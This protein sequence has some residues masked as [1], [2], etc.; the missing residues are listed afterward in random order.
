MARKPKSKPT[1]AEETIFWANEQAGCLYRLRGRRTPKTLQV[2]D[3][4]LLVGSAVS[5][6]WVPFEN[7]RCFQ[8]ARDAKFWLMSKL[9]A[10]QQATADQHTQL[11]VAQATLTDLFSRLPTPDPTLCPECGGKLFVDLGYVRFAD[12]QFVLLNETRTCRACWQPPHDRPSYAVIRTLGHLPYVLQV[13]RISS[14]RDVCSIRVEA[15]LMQGAGTR[16]TYT[17]SDNLPSVSVGDKLEC[18]RTD[19]FVSL[20]LALQEA[21]TV[22]HRTYQMGIERTTHLETTLTQLEALP[23]EH[24]LTI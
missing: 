18:L 22:V 19:C 12:Q 9:R 17:D 3:A 10:Q 8:F 14:Q 7:E 21:Q 11:Q 2:T 15:V 5:P 4:Q 24:A 20:H 6:K 1:E 16:L 13:T 23:N